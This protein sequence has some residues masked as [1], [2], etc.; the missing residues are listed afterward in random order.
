LITQVVCEAH[1]DLD[2]E[3]DELAGL[4]DS[5]MRMPNV[6]ACGWQNWLQTTATGS[7]CSIWQT[8]GGDLQSGASLN[9]ATKTTGTG[10]RHETSPN[11]MQ[12]PRPDHT[13]A[14][15]TADQSS[16]PGITVRG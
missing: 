11:P 16:I 15:A 2:A 5:A 8:L 13:R 9:R 6:N 3:Q 1:F 4:T 10:Q 14:P 12:P 7:C